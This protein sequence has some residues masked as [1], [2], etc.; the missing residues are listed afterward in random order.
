LGAGGGLDGLHA[1]LLVERGA[2]EEDPQRAVAAGAGGLGER[3]DRGPDGGEVR[4]VADDVAQA[5]ASGVRPRQDGLAVLVLDQ[6]AQAVARPRAVERAR[7]PEREGAE[8]LEV[9]DVGLG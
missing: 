9:D 2:D 7:L 6:P 4:D 3:A 5:V 1:T 8:L